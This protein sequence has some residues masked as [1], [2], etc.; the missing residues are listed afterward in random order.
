MNK[1]FKVILVVLL[2]VLLQ[3]VSNS[4]YFS[5][6]NKYINVQY[7]SGYETGKIFFNLTEISTDRLDA[8]VVS[9]F[10]TSFYPALNYGH[11]NQNNG[12]IFGNPNGFLNEYTSNQFKGCEF[13]QLRNTTKKDFVVLREDKVMV[14]QNENNQIQ[15]LVQNLPEGSGIYMDK[16]LFNVD[17]TYEDVVVT[18][19]TQ[20][21]IFRNTLL[22]YL[23]PAYFGPYN[24]TGQI[25]KM[26][27]FDDFASPY[28]QTYANNRYDLIVANGNN[29]SVYLNT[30]NNGINTTAFTS[31]NAQF[32]VRDI[33]VADMDGDGYN[34]L[35]VVGDYQAKVFK[36][37][38]GTGY[39]QN[40]V[41]SVNNYYYISISP[42]VAVADVDMNGRKD[43][44]VTS[45][46]EG[47]TS[48]F[49]NSN[50]VISTTPAQTFNSIEVGQSANQI[51]AV[52]IYNTGGIAL[53]TSFKSGIKIMDASTQNPAPYSPLIQGSYINNNGF[54]RP[55]I[56]I[57]DEKVRDYQ[58][59]AIYKRRPGEAVFSLLTTTTEKTYTD[60][61]ENVYTGQG[62]PRYSQRLSYHVKTVDNTNLSSLPSNQVNYW[63]DGAIPDSPIGGEN[64]SGIKPE[65][66]FLTN[67]PNPFNPKTV[68]YYTIPEAS[69]VKIS[70]YNTVGQV[71]KEYSFSKQSPAAY[72]VDFDGSSLS[73]GIYFYKIQAGNFYDVKKMMLVK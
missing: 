66:Y 25:V 19:G 43:V 53:L 24:I 52:D 10:S 3:S 56:K 60:N 32:T 58:Y 47:Y 1:L 14:F 44:I 62:T 7:P 55:V 16:G 5:N 22:G 8:S 71:I 46:L 33:E 29:V 37:L 28:N 61:T 30:N 51:K 23:D 2:T 13:V 35:I 38:S 21:K 27:Q 40:P 4:Q 68:I 20:V 17:D 50:G 39:E 26:R 65:K 6:N 64:L 48:L 69:D 42:K 72:Q 12:G 31:V 34:D 57:I 54:N 70:V 59:Y 63:I 49:L 15:N 73:S 9:S 18:T 67:Y 11:W 41:W 45:L 36:N